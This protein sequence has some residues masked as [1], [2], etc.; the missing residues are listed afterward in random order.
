MAL[1]EVRDLRKVF[2]RPVKDPGLAGALRH[3]VSRRY[4]DVAAV[5]GIDL[6]VEAGE[7]VAYVGPNGAGK[8]TTV[9]MLSG[10]LVPSSGSLRVGGIVPHEDR[11]ANARQIGVLF[12]QRTQ[13][14]WDLQ[15]RDTLELLREMYAV[16]RRDYAER[17]ERFDEVLGLGELLPVVARK[18]SL[19]QR[20]RADLAAV[21]LHGP[22]VV[23]LDEPTI[24]L[25]ISVRDRVRTFLRSIVEEGTTLML[26]THDLGDIEDVCRR[27]VII[28]HGRIIY[29]GPIARVKDGF[30]R[31]RTVHAQLHGAPDLCGLRE[32]LPGAELRTGQDPGAL[33]VV[34]DRFDLGNGRVVQALAA[35]GDLVDLRIE[36][37][38]VEDVVRRVYAG[39]LE[40]GD[41]DRDG[42]AGPGAT[43]GPAGPARA[44]AG[45][46]SGPGATAGAP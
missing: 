36:E 19:G 11:I 39:D 17:L 43:A 28:D 31:E 3:L 2:R 34:F 30:A 33:T 46:G 29:D 40:L 18:L 8:S 1:I 38:S 16:P 7:A 26:T 12:G 13:Q 44:G 45:G 37:T 27:I 24:G 10:I 42:E 5:D 21:L 23:Y 20:M 15:V 32:A 9:K 22:R 14:W 25:D 35:A 41:L 6:T 4:T